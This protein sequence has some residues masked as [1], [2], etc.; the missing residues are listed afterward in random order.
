MGVL[1]I[2]N[3]RYPSFAGN[4]PKKHIGPVNIS[5]NDQVRL[6]LVKDFVYRCVRKDIGVNQDPVVKD[7]WFRGPHSRDDKY[8]LMPIGNQSL[9]HLTQIRVHSVNDKHNFHGR[10]APPGPWWASGDK[11]LDGF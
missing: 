7:V 3:L 2:E 9:V 10:E 8:T 5:L 4:L 1:G 11:P 6:I